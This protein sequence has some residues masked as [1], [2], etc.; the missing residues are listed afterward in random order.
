MNAVG[1]S[2]AAVENAAMNVE[3]VVEILKRVLAENPNV[4]V[5]P[6][7]ISADTP[8][9]EGGLALDSIVLMELI[10]VI[11]EQLAFEFRDSDLRLKTFQNLRSVAEVAV[12]RRAERP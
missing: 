12:A 11:E 5:V 8:L 6:E 7:K 2:K 1:Q 3:Q 4:T 9:L 10:G